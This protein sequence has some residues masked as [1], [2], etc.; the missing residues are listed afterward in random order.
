MNKVDCVI[1]GKYRKVEKPKRYL[2]EKSQLFL[3]FEKSKNKDEKLFKE[4]E[5][6]RD[7]LNS[8]FD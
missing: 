3:L 6:N 5:S 8:S 1:C 2:L 4:E 7:I